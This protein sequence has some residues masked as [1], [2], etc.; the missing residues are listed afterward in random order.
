MVK[1]GG[2]F[3]RWCMLGEFVTVLQNRVSSEMLIRRYFF[4][5]VRSLLAAAS[6]MA[7]VA[8]KIML[9]YVLWMFWGALREPRLRLI[10]VSESS[11]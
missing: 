8:E 5:A 9:F 2:S 1:I 3:W 11:W 6:D 4:G 10:E 7:A